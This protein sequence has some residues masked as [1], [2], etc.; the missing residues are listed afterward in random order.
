MKA[1]VETPTDRQREAY[2]LRTENGLTYDEIGKRLGV[3]TTRASDLCTQ[4]YKKIRQRN[5]GAPSPHRF[6]MEHFKAEVA[7]QPPALSPGMRQ[8]LEQA[9]A[10]ATPASVLADIERSI[11]ACARLLNNMDVLARSSPSQLG[12]L[13]KDLTDVRA[14]MRGEPTQIVQITDVRKM[15]ELGRM[16]L[17][18]LQRRNITIDGEARVALDEP[19][20]RA[21][22]GT[23]TAGASEDDHG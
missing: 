14:L 18:E 10:K 7:P 6:P 9:M 13:M 20:G 3:S 1:I 5:K 22:V 16:L 15:D 2:R 17:E 21:A 11:A 12:K 23:S 8:Q 4:A 19:R